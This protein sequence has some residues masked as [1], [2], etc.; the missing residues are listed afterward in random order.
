MKLNTSSS[1]FGLRS[2]LQVDASPELKKALKLIAIEEDVSLR[3]LVLQALAYKY[4][5]LRS[6]I[7]AEL[8]GMV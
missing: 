7:K 4:P 3:V 6:K 1:R 5:K 8:D 2:L